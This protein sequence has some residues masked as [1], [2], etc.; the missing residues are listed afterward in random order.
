[1]GKIYVWDHEIQYHEANQIQIAHHPN[2]TCWLEEARTMIMEGVG[3]GYE[4]M[5][6]TGAISPVV[7]VST[8][9]HTMFCPSETLR[10][11][12]EIASYNGV[13]I[14]LCYRVI[15]ETSG[16]LRCTGESERCYL[17]MERKFISLKRSKSEIH[18]ILDAT[19]QGG[20]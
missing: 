4:R 17:D 3:F 14:W 13:H 9:C 15:E 20:T 7:S 16:E 2:Y 10:I 18:T 19:K 12:V 8:K 1:M 6:A 5:E 11:M